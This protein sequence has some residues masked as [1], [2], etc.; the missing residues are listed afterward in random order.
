MVFAMVTKETILSA[1]QYS[2]LKEP[3][4]NYKDNIPSEVGGKCTQSRAD[5]QSQ[6]TFLNYRDELITMWAILTMDEN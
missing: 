4:G 5:E 2:N 6:A 3:Q 1:L